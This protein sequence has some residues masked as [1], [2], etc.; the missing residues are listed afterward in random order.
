MVLGPRRPPRPPAALCIL[1][2]QDDIWETQF[3]RERQGPVEHR[4][5]LPP[6]LFQLTSQQLQGDDESWG[7]GGGV[8]KKRRRVKGGADEYL[9]D[10]SQRV[11][12]EKRGRNGE[13]EQY[14]IM[15]QGKENADND[16]EKDFCEALVMY[17]TRKTLVKTQNGI[18]Y[19]LFASNSVEMTDLP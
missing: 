16:R 12:E 18:F 15:Q 4:L 9:Q 13:E 5:V 14:G 17:R 1:T 11:E 19:G 7:I 8:D 3:P 10:I 6:D 2:W